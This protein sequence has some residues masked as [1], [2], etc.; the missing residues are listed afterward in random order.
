M[1]R[2]IINVLEQGSL[3]A[4]LSI[5]V[6]LTYKIIGMA[7]MSV[8]GTYPLGAVVS[9]V[10]ILNGGNP[11]VSLIVAAFAG[12]LAGCMTGVLHV[13]L[14]ISGL[15]SGILVMTGLYSVNLIIA[16]G[17]SNLSLLNDATLF[18]VQWLVKFKDAAFFGFVE[19]YVLPYYRLIVLV[20]MVLLIKWAVDW[21]L[22]TKLGYL[23]RV[24]GDN[25]S[26]VVA[27]GHDVG[28]VKIIA[29]AISNGLAALSGAVAASVGRYYDVSLGTGMV[30]M[31]LSSVM[32]G[33]LLMKKSSVKMTSMV[34]LGSILYR[35]IVALAIRLGMDPQHMKLITV[36]IFVVAIVLNNASLSLTFMHKKGEV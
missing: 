21:L 26:L 25:E 19:Q 34:I 2:F 15:L 11:W 20:M 27:L 14:R 10:F 12:L 36:V 24:T 5:A 6:M 31:G 3:Y 1:A 18:D 30:V 13:K 9:A 8:D 4:I 29:L 7:D 32:L 33:T 28:K 16:G 35:F 23:L 17:R 22:Q